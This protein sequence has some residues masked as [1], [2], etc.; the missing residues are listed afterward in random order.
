MNDNTVLEIDI[1][2]ILK[3]LWKKR[4]LLVLLILGGV[5]STVIY[6]SFAT[7]LY[8]SEALVL[9]G[10]EMKQNADL[11]NLV[12]MA[13]FSMNNDNAGAVLFPEIIVSRRIL[14]PIITKQYV[15]EAYPNRAISLMEYWGYTEGDSD[16]ADIMQRVVK[17]M[18]KNVVTITTNKRTGVITVAV[19][20]EEPLLSAEIAN[21]ITDGLDAFNRNFRRTKAG[22]ERAFI[23]ERNKVIQTS[24]N[25]AENSLKRF[26]E[27]NRRISDSPSLLLE[28]ERY[29]REVELQQVLYIEMKKQLELV[30]I[31]EVKNM[32]V[33]DVLDRAVPVVQPYKPNVILFFV[34]M[35]FLAII[36]GVFT[37]LVQG[38]YKSNK[39]KILSI[40]Q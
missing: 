2:A 12:A 31:E 28:Q 19:I 8:R 1:F 38:Y 35:M 36:I 40:F 7:R 3:L 29:I 21:G 34:V 6:W 17:Y 39:N 10:R 33:I 14:F 24:L 13:G 4:L 20:T 37:I 25:R 23:Q 9:P 15:T 26:R 5:G 18:R 30:K 32:P 16:T 27:K 22:E 11:Q